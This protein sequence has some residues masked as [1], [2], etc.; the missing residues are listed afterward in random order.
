MSKVAP[1]RPEWILELGYVNNNDPEN[2]S[3]QI[4]LIASIALSF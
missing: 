4:I 2:N 3:I 1:F